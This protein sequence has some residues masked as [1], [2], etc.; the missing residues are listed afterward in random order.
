[1]LQINNDQLKQFYEK[2]QK[3]KLIAVDTEFYRVDTYFPELCLIQLSNSSECIVLDPITKK[4]DLFFLRKVL[5][6]TKIGKVFH[7][8]RQ[9]I[10]IFFNIFKKIPRP[11]TDTQICL[12]ALGY[13]HST[14]YAKACEDFL[15]VT[16]DKKKQF[17]DWRKRPLNKKEITYALNDV[18]YLLPLF[19]KISSKLNLSSKNKLKRYYK[20]VTCEKIFTERAEM[21]WK[22]IRFNAKNNSE[23]IK[24]KKYCRIRENLAMKKNVP[25]KRIISDQEI[26]II[27]RADGEKNLISRIIKKLEI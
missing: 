21:A 13:P 20:K 12:I 24:L 23:Q 22:K 15:G 11:V 25:A 16:L 7:A 5:F 4:L 27:S 26:K 3:D 17:I 8:A 1:V 2:C 10:E 18:K 6:N 14:S 9:D 19:K